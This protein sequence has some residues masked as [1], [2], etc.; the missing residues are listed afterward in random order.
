MFLSVH[1]NLWNEKML[2]MHSAHNILTVR[3]Y[4]PATRMVHLLDFSR[5]NRQFR[6]HIDTDVDKY[7]YHHIPT[8]HFPLNLIATINN[9]SFHKWIYFSLQKPWIIF[10]IKLHRHIRN[11][12]HKQKHVNVKKNP[13][14][15]HSVNILFFFFAKCVRHNV[16]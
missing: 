9:K 3:L 14:L 2:L 10:S 12:W 8:V 11:K 4:L 13:T 15:S 16:N 1:N 6:Q 5:G 7:S